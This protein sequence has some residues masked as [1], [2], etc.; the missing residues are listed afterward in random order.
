MHLVMELLKN[1]LRQTLLGAVISQA[2]LSPCC[3]GGLQS[4]GKTGC[5]GAI[6]GLKETLLPLCRGPVLLASCL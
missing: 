1:E 3:K 5:T 4:L 6:E 2:I